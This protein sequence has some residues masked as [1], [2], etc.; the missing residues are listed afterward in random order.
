MRLF[1]F[2]VRTGKVKRKCVLKFQGEGDE[3]KK[4]VCVRV[5]TSYQGNHYFKYW[6]LEMEEK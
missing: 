1:T 4:N 3:N 5:H 2:E 6:M